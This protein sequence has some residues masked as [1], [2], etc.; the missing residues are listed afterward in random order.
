M[1]KPLRWLHGEVKT[2]PMGIEA[3]RRMG[4]MLRVLQQGETIG[5]PHAKPMKT[6]G[7]HCIELRVPDK[8]QAWR[9]ICSIEADAVVVLDVFNKKSQQTPK[10][11][12]QQCKRR[13]AMYHEDIS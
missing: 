12:I 10:T 8:G 2:P 13:L 1:N 3:R 9:L 5:M 7:S 11:V 6:I 4:F